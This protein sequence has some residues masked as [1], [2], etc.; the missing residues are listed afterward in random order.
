[1]RIQY[2]QI[3]TMVALCVTVKGSSIEDALVNN[4]YSKS[5]TSCGDL[6]LLV[7]MHNLHIWA[8]PNDPMGQIPIGGR[9]ANS[10]AVC[11]LK[12]GPD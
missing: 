5:Y 11:S 8:G 4:K 1:M 10:P 9:N 12:I 6:F 2:G 7:Q 3:L